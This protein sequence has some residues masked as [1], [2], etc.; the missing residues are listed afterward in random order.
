MWVVVACTC[1]VR[2]PQ[3]TD[4]GIWGFPNYG[5]F[6]AAKQGVASPAQLLV[7]RSSMQTSGHH[8]FELR[9]F[10]EKKPWPV[11]GGLLF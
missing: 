4:F 2:V 9:T 10:A 7:E 6:V 11:A 5:R 3:S 1:L 8:A